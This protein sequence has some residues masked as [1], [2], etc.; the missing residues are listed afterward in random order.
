[1]A[2]SLI[3][4]GQVACMALADVLH[5][6]AGR[7]SRPPVQNRRHPRQWAGVSPYNG[8][9]NSAC[10][11]RALEKRRKAHFF[12]ETVTLCSL[13]PLR[14]PLLNDLKLSGSRGLATSQ[15]GPDCSELRMHNKLCSR[16]NG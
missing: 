4:A 3:C 12:V 7:C 13:V 10:P 16:Y 1:M 15:I 5:T 8:L 14:Y 9:A 6:P 11:L 2:F